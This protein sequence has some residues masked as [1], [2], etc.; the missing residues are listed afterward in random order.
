MQGQAQLAHPFDHPLSLRSPPFCDELELWLIADEVNLEAAGAS[1]LVA[2]PERPGNAGYSCEPL[3]RCK[4]RTF[5]D[6]DSPT[7]SACVYRLA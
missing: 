5:P 7:T 1:L 2:E 4:A 3:V 6:V